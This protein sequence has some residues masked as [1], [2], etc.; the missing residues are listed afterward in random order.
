M[1]TQSVKSV[2]TDVGDSFRFGDSY[3]ISEL[4]QLVMD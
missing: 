3:H 2:M 1:I 4:C